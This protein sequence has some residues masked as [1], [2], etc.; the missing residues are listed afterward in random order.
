MTVSIAHLSGGE[1][2]YTAD[3]KETDFGLPL[4]RPTR[5]R[6]RATVRTVR[7]AHRARGGMVVWFE[8]GTKTRPMHGRTVFE[9]AGR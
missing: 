1:R 4:V 8:D 7:A 6:V 2:V 3:L 5:G 9:E